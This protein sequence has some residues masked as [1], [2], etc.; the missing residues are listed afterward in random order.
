MADI[1]LAE[2]GG[3][4]WLVRGEQH[5]DDLLANTLPAG[6]SVE[7]VECGSRAE[8][9]LLWAQNAASPSASGVPWLIHPR[10]VARARGRLADMRVLFAQWSAML[11]ER[12]H[13][14]IKAAAISA[15][16]NT[17]VGL[18]LTRF[19]RP[20]SGPMLASLAELRSDLIAAELV[21]L[22]VAADRIGRETRDISAVPEMGE[23]SQRIDIGFR[24]P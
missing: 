19:I 16:E 2:F 15:G 5:V 20:E 14:A 4:A 8:V 3:Q 23:E 24:A 17:G 7:I 13:A 12:A 1:V 21:K 9:D 22:G 6:I 11:D 10:I 18:V